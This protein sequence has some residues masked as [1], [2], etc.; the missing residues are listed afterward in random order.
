MIDGGHVKEGR[1]KLQLTKAVFL[2]YLFTVIIIGF[3]VQGTAGLYFRFKHLSFQKDLIVVTTSQAGRDLKPLA[4]QVKIPIKIVPQSVI[5]IWDTKLNSPVAN[6]FPKT[7]FIL[8]QKVDRLYN[9]N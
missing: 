5:L 2:R 1:V 9:Y 3:I 8:G 7:F 4:D 6:D